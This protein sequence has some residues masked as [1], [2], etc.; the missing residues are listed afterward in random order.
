MDSG[1]RQEVSVGLP[2]DLVRQ[3]PAGPLAR[4]AWPFIYLQGKSVP[5]TVLWGSFGVLLVSALLCVLFFRGEVRFDRHLFFLGA[6]FL[7]VETRTI[8]QLGLELG[9][10]WRVSAITIAAILVIVLGANAVVRRFGALPRVP[11]YLALGAALVANAAIP[12]RAVLGG[13]ALAAWGMVAFLLVPLFCA[14][15]IFASS[16]SE[17][18]SLGPALASNLFGSVLGGLLENSV[19]VV[20]IPGL[21]LVALAVY[22]A[23]FRR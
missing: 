11:L 4:D 19:M 22:A 16:V 5:A 14:G 20:G 7:L 15:L 10:T 23:S 8:A 18:E 3:H 17:R 2:P 12:A 9:S 21:S 13:G 6:G 1:G